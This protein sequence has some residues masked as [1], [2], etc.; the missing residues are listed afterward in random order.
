MQ[1]CARVSPLILTTIQWNTLHLQHCNIAT[2]VVSRK[3]LKSW[4]PSESC[5]SDINTPIR[6]PGILPALYSLR[7]P[8]SSLISDDFKMLSFR[9]VLLVFLHASAVISAATG[10]QHETIVLNS[11][12]R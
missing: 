9:A 8:R 1:V 2:P 5:A 7:I 12:L 10:S 3:S 11:T 4:L 6:M